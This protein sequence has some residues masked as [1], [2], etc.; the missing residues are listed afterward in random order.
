[1]E[2]FG[3]QVNLKLVVE[4]IEDVKK[5][6]GKSLQSTIN[7][8]M[9]KGLSSLASNMVS[10][11]QQ[12][13]FGTGGGAA[14]G[15]LGKLIG[16]TALMLGAL[17]VIGEGVKKIVNFLSSSSPILH[18]ILDIFKRSMMIFFR[19]F[20]DFLG[21]LLKPMAV[22]L[23][24]M[25]VAFLQWM[26]PFLKGFAQ[27]TGQNTPQSGVGGVGQAAGIVA[28]QLGTTEPITLLQEAFE[29]AK[30]LAK[31]AKEWADK[32]MKDVFGV[33]MNKVRESVAVFLLQKV[34]A[35]FASIPGLLAEGFSTL[36]SLGN[37]VM[38]K[39]KESWGTLTDLGSQIWAWIKGK[40][41]ESWGTL[42]NLAKLAWDFIKS[43]VTGKGGSSTE[44]RYNDKGQ[45]LYGPGFQTGL[46]F[47]P[48]DGWYKLHRGEQVM[49]ATR[50]NTGG[51]GTTILKPTFNINGGI[52]SDID[53]DSLMRRGA[54]QI[55]FAMRRRAI[56]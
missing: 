49:P 17:Q 6:V 32:I 56:I 21:I 45:E 39:I 23:L 22:A 18:G 30:N 8:N 10:G 54:R 34:P 20:G 19:P 14:G 25:S 33:D 2:V 52:N 50:T 42:T 9:M 5:H 37:V 15:G 48:D 29:G 24:K 55:E 12:G 7:K 31:I 4:N 35:F 16:K 11:V 13:A 53:I 41:G 1:M 28:G 36:K 26:A 47:V 3:M 43:L 44:P 38:D 51:G 27:G 46:N 40:L